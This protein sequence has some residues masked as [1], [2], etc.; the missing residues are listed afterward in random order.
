MTHIQTI[1]ILLLVFLSCRSWAG[2]ESHGGE[3]RICQ[4][5]PSDVAAVELLDYYK[6]KKDLKDFV[7]DL[8]GP[9]LSV[10]E[11]V[12]L[13]LLR[14]KKFDPISYER[15]KKRANQFDREIQFETTWQ[16]FGP[17][18]DSG[19]DLLDMGQGCRRVRVVKQRGD[20]RKAFE[21]KYIVYKPHWDLA[22]TT[23]LAGIK[24]HEIFYE[25]A[26][27]NGRFSSEGIIYYN[28]LMSSTA[29]K[30]L[31]PVDYYNLLVDSKLDDS[32]HFLRVDDFLF[33]T[34][35]SIQFDSSGTV[36]S[37]FL[38]EDIIFRN[39]DVKMVAR[40]NTPI[41]FWPN[42]TV[43]SAHLK[44]PVVLN[45]QGKFVTLEN[46]TA[47]FFPNGSLRRGYVSAAT[48][49]E[50]EDGSAQKLEGTY[51]VQFNE[52]QK[53]ISFEKRFPPDPH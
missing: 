39:N 52:N 10:D 29:A 13:V 1:L 53:L 24:L 3:F 12:E 4:K 20:D 2:R 5:S 48:T 27:L 9:N 16:R 43:G 45:I 14:V 33:Q 22:D 35:N 37:A 23:T 15:L 41:E 42:G 7:L 38:A 26:I 51:Y 25:D 21:K 19:D 6:A 44:F 32:F 46:F 30:K 11:K 40:A 36:A 31:T 49:L 28:S 18:L 17:A 50:Q 34:K 47:H 8:G